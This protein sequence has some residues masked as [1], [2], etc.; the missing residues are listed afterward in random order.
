MTLCVSSGVIAPLYLLPRLPG[1]VP[2]PGLSWLGERA[3]GSYYFSCNPIHACFKNQ[4]VCF[5]D[6]LKLPKGKCII[7]KYL[8]RGAWSLL[9]WPG[10]A[11]R[12]NTADSADLEGT[13]QMTCSYSRVLQESDKTVIINQLILDKL[14]FILSGNIIFPLTNSTQLSY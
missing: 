1:D 5:N 4:A 3:P 8:F 2:R 7:N 14:K 10:V 12:D 6:F 11:G 9:V 13:V